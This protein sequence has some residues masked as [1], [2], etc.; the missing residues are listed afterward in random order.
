MNLKKLKPA[1]LILQAL[2]LFMPV[3]K[4]QKERKIEIIQ[5]ELLNL[6]NLICIIQIFVVPLQ[7]IS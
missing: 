6:N 7:R 3:Y 1:E 4:V 5:N 2:F